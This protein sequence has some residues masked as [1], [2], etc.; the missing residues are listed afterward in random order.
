[1]SKHHHSRVLSFVFVRDPHKKKRN[2]ERER[3]K[4]KEMATKQ[5]IAP[6]FSLSPQDILAL[7]GSFAVAD[8]NKDGSLDFGEFE[9]L[10]SSKGITVR[11]IIFIY[12]Y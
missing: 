5:T 6:K 8:K 9:K 4:K 11:H 7:N 1:M 10:F 3:R 2:H 12:I